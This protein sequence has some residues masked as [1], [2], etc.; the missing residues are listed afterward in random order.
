MA[1]SKVQLD[2]WFDNQ[3]ISSVSVRIPQGPLSR[4]EFE[5]TPILDMRGIPAGFHIIKVEMFELWTS[6]ERLTQAG[7]EV[8]VEH[9]P[10]TRESRFVKIP[11]V[12]SIAGADLAVESKSEKNVYREI[13]KTIKK[14]Q[15]SKR[16]DW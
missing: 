7:K 16:D 5:L 13:E 6:G 15:L 10:Q 9:M 2:L 14:E 8:K 3:K 12:K 4:D 1:F 11:T